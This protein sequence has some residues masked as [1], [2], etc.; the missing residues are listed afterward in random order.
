MSR[1]PYSTRPIRTLTDLG[2]RV[3]QVRES[4]RATATSV[5]QRSNRSRDILYRLERGEDISVSSLLDIV[6]AI[7]CQLEL[8]PA[9]TPTLEEVQERF[10]EDES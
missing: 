9:R 1:V 8:V 5:S 3:A 6:R 7:G 4:A 10:S 2:A